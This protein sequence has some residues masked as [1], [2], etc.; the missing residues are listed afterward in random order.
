MKYEISQETLNKIM[1]ALSSHEYRDDVP[2]DIG[3]SH[4]DAKNAL[5]KEIEGQQ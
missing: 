5:E 1:F 2:D 3:M 4:M